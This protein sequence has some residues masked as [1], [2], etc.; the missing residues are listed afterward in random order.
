MRA[1][2][3]LLAAACSTAPMIYAQ[4]STLP[5]VTLKP[6]AKVEVP[7]KPTGVAVW[8]GHMRWSR[9]CLRSSA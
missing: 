7:K 8:A 6:T 5:L 3:I 4:Q 9:K 2:A 1:K